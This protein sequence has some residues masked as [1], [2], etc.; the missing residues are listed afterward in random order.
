MSYSARFSVPSS[1]PNGL[2]LTLLTLSCT[3]EVSSAS[4]VN[5]CLVDE[6]TGTDPSSRVAK[7]SGS[8]V[9]GRNGHVLVAN[10]NSGIP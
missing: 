4:P 8:F 5:G 10:R 7:V 1:T 6:S 2:S 3:E 9:F